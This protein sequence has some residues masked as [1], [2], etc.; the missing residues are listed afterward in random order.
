M[1]GALDNACVH[2]FWITRLACSDWSDRE[3]PSLSPHCYLPAGVPEKKI[4]K[5]KKDT[6]EEEH[7][8]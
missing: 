3:I 5:Q 8:S 4:T 6:Q 2:A 1:H 7:L